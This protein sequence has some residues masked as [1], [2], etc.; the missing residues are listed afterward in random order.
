MYEVRQRFDAPALGDVRGAVREALAP[1]G[2]CEGIRPGQKVAVG[3]GSRGIHDLR[4]LVAAAVECL[5]GLG[6]APFIVPAMGSHGGAT[7]RGQAR[8]LARLG[9]TE[10]TLGAPVRS[11]ME[12]VPLGR[13]DHG[14]EVFFA[15]DAL[16]A[17]HV[18]A[19]NRVKPHTAFRGEVESGLCKM[20]VIGLGKQRGAS[21]V[22][23][24]G[25]ARTIVPAARMILE[26]A[27]ILCGLA[28]LETPAGGT[29]RVRMA[30][31][32]AFVETDRE[33][34][35]EAWALLPRLPLDDL[36]ILLVD[37]MGKDISGAGMDPNVIG[38]WR[39]EGG[40]RRPDYRTLVVLDLTA[41]SHG[42]ATGLGMA[43]LTTQRVMAKVDLQ[44]TY[45]NALTSG[46]LRSAR[47]PVAVANDR[48]AIRVALSLVPDPS[49]V[50]MARIASTLSLGTFWASEA[51][52]PELKG[53]PGL[54]ID[55]TPRSL[56]FDD[57]GRLQLM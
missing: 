54:K 18:V 12:V 9:V 38:F 25:L 7:A 48:E 13:L 31:A 15:R 42:N 33:L 19:I 34:L 6:L 1:L 23:R 14:C 3:V 46:V 45:M 55:P 26:R 56:R 41:E 35:R 36:D 29:S 52:L 20:L 28:V 50:R 5:R 17:D 30:L 49:G 16:E 47:M 24:H 27:P 10:E 22:H 32:E 2:G 44:A 53:R 8:V 39:R 4:D 21:E 37:A 40:E 11:G 57:S 43:D 51:L